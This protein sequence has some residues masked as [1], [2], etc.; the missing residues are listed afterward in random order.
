MARPRKPRLIPSSITYTEELIR[1]L[2]K[3]AATT[4]ARATEDL[5]RR[6]RDLKKGLAIVARRMTVLGTPPAPTMVAAPPKND[7]P[8][9]PL[10][11]R[12]RVIANELM[13]GAGNRDIAKR[14][15]LSVRTV[16]THRAHILKKLN[17]NS[18]VGLI[19]YGN[20]KGVLPPRAPK[21]EGV[22]VATGRGGR[23]KKRGRRRR[24]RTGR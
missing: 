4:L 6:I 17:V 12:E 15:Q 10:T 18:L 24:R 21:A 20:E 19:L 16:E 5:T 8:L 11:E 3:E 22:A 1:I 9:F 7:D 23:P 2:T 14:H 13:A